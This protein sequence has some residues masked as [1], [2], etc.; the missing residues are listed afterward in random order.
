MARTNPAPLKTARWQEVRAFVAHRAGFRC[1]HCHVFLGRAGE[2]DHRIPRGTCELLGVG[3]YDPSN[4]QYLCTSCHSA[5]TNA[6]RW[7][8]H[9]P[10]PPKQPTRSKVAGRDQYLNATGIPQPERNEHA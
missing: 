3:T 6:E 5:K 1:E 2:V 10:K 4:C 9:T 8:G 7:A